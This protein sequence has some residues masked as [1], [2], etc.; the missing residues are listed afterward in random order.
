M[1]AARSRVPGA[2]SPSH[3]PTPPPLSLSRKVLIWSGAETLAEYMVNFDQLV[4]SSRNDNYR[5]N[6]ELCLTSYL[7]V[8]LIFAV[9]GQA[10]GKKYTHYELLWYFGRKVGACSM[11]IERHQS[12]WNF[13]RITT[14][15]S[16]ILNFTGYRFHPASL[17]LGDPC[18][19][20]SECA[21]THSVCLAVD[22]ANYTCQCKENYVAVDGS[23][24]PRE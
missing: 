11:E 5:F 15:I 1:T 4:H 23:C 7:A 18:T 2:P 16:S 8:L 19:G 14:K 6:V 12:L 3:N 17:S 24:V 13:V 21:V 22:E 10:S 20:N 9:H